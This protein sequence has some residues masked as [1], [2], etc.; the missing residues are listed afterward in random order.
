MG[1]PVLS[2]DG[3]QVRITRLTGSSYL[4]NTLYT[5]LFFCQEGDNRVLTISQKKFCADGNI[6]GG[7]LYN[8]GGG[9]GGAQ[10]SLNLTHTHT[11]THTHTQGLNPCNGRSPSP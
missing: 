4:F 11:H 6:T 2:V 9:A 7:Q 1:Y 3:K 8:L 10:I 5:C